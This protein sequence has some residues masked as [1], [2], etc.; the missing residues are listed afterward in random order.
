M[1]QEKVGQYD[2]MADYIESVFNVFT[3]TNKKAEQQND[4]RL[5]I[6]AMTIFNYV[7][8]M[9]TEYKVDLKTISEPEIINLIPIFEYVSYKNIEF[10]D[11]NNIDINDVDVNKK[12][13]LERFVL[14]HVY[15][16]T[17]KNAK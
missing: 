6:I 16:I 12:E 13:D 3:I 7:K 2:K 15:Y 10:Y 8:Y 5:K 9:A 11:F 1:N 17:Q 4:K 14:S